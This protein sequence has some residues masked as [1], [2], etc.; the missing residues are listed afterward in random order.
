MQQSTQRSTAL[1]CGRPGASRLITN[2]ASPLTE[3]GLRHYSAK[4]PLALPHLRRRIARIVSTNAEE[5]AI[6]VVNGFSELFLSW[7]SSSAILKYF[8][9]VG[10]HANNEFVVMPIFARIILVPYGSG[11]PFP[12]EEWL[13]YRL[14]TTIFKCSQKK[15]FGGAG[16]SRAL[17]L[18]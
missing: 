6:T 5:K 4:R 12:K 3:S 15:C 1:N 10:L 9:L 2:L 14:Q 8:Y 7:M 17:S 18:L 11:R 16:S 13:L